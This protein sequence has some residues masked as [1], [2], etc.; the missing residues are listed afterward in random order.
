MVGAKSDWIHCSHE[1]WLQL[2]HKKAKTSSR[3]TLCRLAQQLS[4]LQEGVRQETNTS[5]WRFGPVAERLKALLQQDS[6]APH[7]GEQV[8]HLRPRQHLQ[9]APKRKFNAV[10]WAQMQGSTALSCTLRAEPSAP[11]GHKMAGGSPWHFMMFPEPDVLHCTTTGASPLSFRTLTGGWIPIVYRPCRT[12]PKCADG[13]SSSQNACLHACT[14]CFSHSLQA[15]CKP[16]CSL[17]L[18]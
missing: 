16:T 8:I 7:H 3:T 10:C 15:S 6:L 17:A 1:L 12:L 5:A 13:M 4:R 11:A 14:G 2:L 9:Q 18:T